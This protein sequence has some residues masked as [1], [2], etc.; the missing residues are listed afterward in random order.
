[1]T[2]KAIQEQ[3]MDIKKATQAA[4]KT[5]ESAQKFLISAGLYP[6]H[7]TSAT[8]LTSTKKK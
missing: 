5:K 8:K 1:M 7:T 3:I 4:V 6:E 2:E